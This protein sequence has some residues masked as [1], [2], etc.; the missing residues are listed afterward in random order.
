MAKPKNRRDDSLNVEFVMKVLARDRLVCQMCGAGPFDT[1]PYMPGEH[2][3]LMLDNR[4]FSSA[5][6]IFKLSDWRTLC[7]TCKDGI[8]I[9][10]QK[11]QL[12][13]PPTLGQ[14]KQELKKHSFECLMACIEALRMRVRQESLKKRIE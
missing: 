10:K 4:G 1:D 11:G 13:P 12:I 8:S 2:I 5:K 14:L 3:S 6:G 7:S 9:L